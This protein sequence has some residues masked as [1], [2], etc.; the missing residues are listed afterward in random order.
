ME[1]LIWCGWAII[2]NKKNLLTKRVGTKKNYPNYWTFPAWT[3]EESDDT[4]SAAAAREVK[5]EVN[6]NF[7]PTKKLNFYET[8]TKEYRIIG[9]V[10]LWEWDWEIK[11]LESEVSEIWWF[12]YDETTKL[13]IAYSY[14]ETLKDLF[15]LNLIN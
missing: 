11:A 7:T 6:L 8:T 3:L 4:L 2:K 9:F 15:D 1:V 13:E 10:F 14:N 5:E 12:N